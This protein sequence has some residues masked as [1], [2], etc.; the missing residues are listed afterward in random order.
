MMN[1]TSSSFIKLLSVPQ[2]RGRLLLASAPGWTA[3]T[4][5]NENQLI[6]KSMTFF[7]ATRELRSQSKLAQTPSA[8][9]ERAYTLT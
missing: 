4:L 6:S 3:P 7:E 5:N 1:W 8:F 9:K 2:D